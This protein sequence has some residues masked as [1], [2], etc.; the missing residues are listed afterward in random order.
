MNDYVNYLVEII[1][2]IDLS[3]LM[4]NYYLKE[5]E[6]EWSMEAY[7]LHQTVEIIYCLEGTGHLCFDGDLIRMSKRELVI[8]RQDIRH[9]LHMDIK[10]G[11]FVNIQ[12]NTSQLTGNQQI[13]PPN[14]Y[15]AHGYI[16][17]VDNALIGDQMKNVAVE[18]VNKDENYDMLV[19]SEIIGIIIRLNRVINSSQK[20]LTS[21]KYILQAMRFIDNS[22]ENVTPGTVAEAIHISAGYLMHLFK[23]LTGKTIM[24]Y[25][26]E[27]RMERGKQMLINTNLKISEIAHEL[28]YNSI[29]HFSMDFKKNM[30]LS[31]GKFRSIKQS[32]N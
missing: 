21:D 28:R 1:K 10:G 25:A 23:K 29:S 18:M 5:F 32:V 17:L 2:D 20:A 3:K 9:L 19:K 13:F 12:L 15:N 30:G 4:I 27:V 6:P 7:H 31:P 14:A 26:A 22:T 24:Q 16:K 8:I 11:R